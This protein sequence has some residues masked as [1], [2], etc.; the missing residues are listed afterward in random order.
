MKVNL[1]IL[2][3]KSN[4]IKKECTKKELLKIKGKTSEIE[5]KHEEK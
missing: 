1:K 2:K 3:F 5:N 4:K